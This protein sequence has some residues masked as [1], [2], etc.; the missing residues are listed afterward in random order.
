MKRFFGMAGIVLLSAVFV[1][2]V[3]SC[4]K[5]SSGQTGVKTVVVGTGNKYEPYCYLD[6]NGN[7][8]G[9]DKAVSDEVD[10]RLE[11]YTFVYETFDF[12]NVLVS[13]NTG[14]VD[15]GV[16][17]FEENPERRK[18]YLYG[19]EGY[20]DYDSYLV[21]SASGPYATI[22]SLDEIAG[23]K[24]AVLGVSAASNHEAFV[25]T[26]NST[27]D[28]NHQIAFETYSDDE[29]MHQNIA[30]GRIIGRLSTIFDVERANA[31]ITGLDLKTLGDPVI[32]SKAYFIFRKD[33]AE[34]Q[35]AVDR[36]LR[37][38]KADGTLDKI[39]REVLDEY[40]NNL[41]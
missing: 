31:L 15:I 4:A 6:A 26:Y 11:E 40:Y 37:Q 16:H 34:L 14:K 19:E 36:A 5:K 9:F 2:P 29:I 7:L 28:A 27:H 23:N 10:K 33:N 8:V 35:Q 38:I 20:N 22:S 17:E 1:L 18:V 21:V 41:K 32:I 30:S 13:L 12:A 39:K 24:D 3:I 25:K